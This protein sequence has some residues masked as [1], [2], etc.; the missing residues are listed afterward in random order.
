MALCA[1]RDGRSGELQAGENMA[2]AVT[3]RSSPPTADWS[4]QQNVSFVVAFPRQ[5]SFS[6]SYVN[7]RE[8][9]YG[10][11]FLQSN[12][13]ISPDQLFSGSPNIILLY[14]YSVI[15]R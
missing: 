9:R 4:A 1:T 3:E 6:L 14:E 13:H 12:T 5:P 10:K 11:S 15:H 8:P 2:I 7:L